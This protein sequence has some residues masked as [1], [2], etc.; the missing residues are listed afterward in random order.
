MHRE[1]AWSA[2]Q[3]DNQAGK[4]IYAGTQ[5]ITPIA[6][7]VKLQLP[8]SK[9]LFYWSRP[10]A[11]VVQAEDGTEQVLSIHDA[12]RWY[13]IAIFSFGLLFAMIFLFTKRRKH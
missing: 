6:Q 10:A 8:G 1:T 9:A 4:P 2:F 5:K 7:V 12:T 11:V 3:I 13:Q